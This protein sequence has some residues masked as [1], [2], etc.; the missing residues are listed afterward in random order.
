MRYISKIFAS[1]WILQ[2][3]FFIW[4]FVQLGK[5][6]GGIG[7]IAHVGASLLAGSLLICAL[8]STLFS[9]TLYKNK[10]NIISLAIVGAV[11]AYLLSG[12]FFPHPALQLLLPRSI[13]VAR[14]IIWP[15]LG[16]LATF[17]LTIPATILVVVS[18]RNR[19]K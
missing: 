18:K 3:V 1:L 4:G 8:A 12:I 7:Y 6:I 10:P 14:E 11:S 16:G 5:S 2:A 19:K 17:T 15:Y 13:M 9:I